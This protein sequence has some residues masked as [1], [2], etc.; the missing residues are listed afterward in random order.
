V[1]TRAA[2]AVS[3]VALML[4]AGIGACSKDEADSDTPKYNPDPKS[5]NIVA[6]L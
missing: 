3:S 6:G 2:V 5:L 4:L 1:R